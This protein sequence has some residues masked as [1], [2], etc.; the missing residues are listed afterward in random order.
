MPA[1]AH[2]DVSRLAAAPHARASPARPRRIL[3]L[4]L[5]RVG[6]LVMVLDAI[7]MVRAMAPE[8]AI[9]LVVG[10]WNRPLAG[11]IPGVN[12]I[13]TLDVPWIARDG[14]GLSW[15]ALVSRAKAW[16]RNG[17]DLAINFE[18]DI[19]SNLLL[20]L[21][22]APRRVGFLSGGGGAVADRRDLSRSARAH[23]RQCEGARR[24][25]IR[26]SRIGTAGQPIGSAGQPTGSAGQPTGSAGQPTGSAGLQPCHA[27][28]SR[29]RAPESSASSSAQPHAS[30]P[31]VGIQPATGRRI[32]E[33]D[34]IR[35]AEVGAEI[36]RTRGASVVLVGS[37]G[38]KPVL[39]AVRAAWPPGCASH[40]AAARCR[41]RCP[42]GGSRALSLFITGDTGPMHLA[43]AVGTPVLA[44][45]GP[46]LPTRYAPLVAA[47]ENRAHR[48]P[49]QP[50]QPDAAAADALPRPRARLPRRHRHGRRAPRCERNAGRAMRR[51]RSLVRR[52]LCAAF[53]AIV[54][55]HSA[56]CGTTL[57]PS[58]PDALRFHAS[59]DSA[60]CPSK[61]PRSRSISDFSTST[62]PCPARTSAHA[63]AD[64]STCPSRRRSSSSPAAT[65]R[66]SCAS[67][68]SVLLTRNLHRRDADDRPTGLSRRGRAR[69]RR[70]LS[71]VRRRDGVEH[72]ARARGT[73]AGAILSGRAVRTTGRLAARPSAE[74]GALDAP[75]HSLRV[76]RFRRSAD[77]Q[78]H[79][80]EF[81][82]VAHDGGA[83]ERARIWRATLARSPLRP[84]WCLPSSSAGPAHHL[85]RTT[86]PSSPS[87]SENWQRRGF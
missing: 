83:A 28:H 75:D 17:Y 27:D 78:R 24:A 38:D 52:P 68:A 57:A 84:C 6:D 71:A 48:Y 72:S 45:F 85:R 49:L 76:D 43:A 13:E 36:A 51:D 47:L 66:S 9:D 8:A 31:L 42:R 50:V 70:R 34:P 7:A 65:T 77:R 11:L 29:R 61:R 4:R 55:A 86:P 10:S 46:S 12:S 39:D 20:A 69:D 1:S 18:P 81:Q 79:G 22:G 14:S 5:E 15:G 60:V 53:A 41:S 35:F 30:A 80:Y 44:I 54:S 37:T 64:F 67:M 82:H 40:R 26:D 73:A 3:L 62:P 63:G 2:R 25:R 56:D 74:R 87:R 16:R 23:C 32:K 19:R 58:R 21:S 33:W 59:R